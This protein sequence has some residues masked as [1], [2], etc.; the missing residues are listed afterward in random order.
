MLEPASR[1]MAETAF[2]AKK[3]TDAKNYIFDF[4]RLR[5]CPELWRKFL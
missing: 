3:K 5:A 2:G 4:I 1:H